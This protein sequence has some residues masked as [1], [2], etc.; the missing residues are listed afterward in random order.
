MTGDCKIPLIASS[1]AVAALAAAFAA[2][3]AAFAAF[4][5]AAAAFAAFAS[6]PEGFDF[7]SVV[8]FTLV[9]VPRA[10]EVNVKSPAAIKAQQVPNLN[11][12]ITTYP[13]LANPSLNFA[14]GSTQPGVSL[15]GY[16]TQICA[17]NVIR[18]LRCYK[19][20]YYFTLVFI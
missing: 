1:A 14:L 5:A 8:F 11:L 12:S 17:E 7:K 18:F 9:S 3:A 4:A 15:I 10:S 2:F 20:F 19:F 6:T 16:S 13:S